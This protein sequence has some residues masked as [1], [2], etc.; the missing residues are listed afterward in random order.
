MD[1]LVIPQSQARSITYQNYIESEGVET[2]YEYFD[3]VRFLIYSD[4][5]IGY[6]IIP[7]YLLEPSEEILE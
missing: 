7:E 3:K 2:I 5:K 6:E 4:N 1:S